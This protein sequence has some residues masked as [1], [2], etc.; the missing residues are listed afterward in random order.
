MALFMLSDFEWYRELP[1]YATLLVRVESECARRLFNIFSTSP[2]FFSFK[3]GGKQ[4]TTLMYV[5]KDRRTAI[6]LKRYVC[7]YAID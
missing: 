6:R 2:L 3:D 4:N 7:T 5:T 1:S